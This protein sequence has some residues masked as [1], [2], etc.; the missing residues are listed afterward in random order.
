LEERYWHQ[1]SPRYDESQDEAKSSVKGEECPGIFIP[2]DLG[3]DDMTE[4]S[5]LNLCRSKFAEAVIMRFGTGAAAATALRARGSKITAP[6]LSKWMNLSRKE[7]M[8]QP[9]E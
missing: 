8:T 6:K 1:D 7:K 5:Y 3:A 4:D 2:A 9:V